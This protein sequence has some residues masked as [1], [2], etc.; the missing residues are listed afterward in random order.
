MFQGRKLGARRLDGL[1]WR[2]SASG[3]RVQSRMKLGHEDRCESRE[4][5]ERKKKR[6]WRGNDLR[7][8]VGRLDRL[9]LPTAISVYA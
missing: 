1:D 5:K 2:L 4:T 3:P 6:T 7:V 9:A 8:P